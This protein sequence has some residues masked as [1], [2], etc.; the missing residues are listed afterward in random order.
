MK[1]SKFTQKYNFR[2]FFKIVAISQYLLHHLLMMFW[3]FHALKCC[4]INVGE[5]QSLI[6]QTVCKP[7]CPHVILGCQWKASQLAIACECSHIMKPS[8]EWIIVIQAV[9]SNV[10]ICWHQALQPIDSHAEEFVFVL[11]H[12]ISFSNNMSNYLLLTKTILFI[13][14]LNKISTESAQPSWIKLAL[15]SCAL[16]K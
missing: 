13:H 9:K 14:A 3:K 4:M 12:Q 8:M 7:L 16:V 11:F 15:Q 6:H 5:F 10:V 1:L 2:L